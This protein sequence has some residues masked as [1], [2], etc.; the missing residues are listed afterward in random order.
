MTRSE[1]RAAI[2]ARMRLR[3]ILS[4]AVL[5]L[6]ACGSADGRPAGDSTAA[7]DTP[8]TEGSAQA[9]AGAAAATGVRLVRVASFTQP[10]Y[11]TAPP[12]DR[13]RQ[14]V[15]E[16][17][18][19]IMIVRN[20][21]K[22]SRPFLD[23]RS[24]VM[25]GGE[26][27]LLGLAF[28]PDYQTS[29]RFYVYFTDRQAKQRLVG[30]R[31]ADADRANPATAE[32]VFVHDDPEANH[33]GGMITFGPDGHLYVGTG[34]GGGGGDQHG[35][36]GNAQ[37]LSSPLGKLLRIDP[38]A[39]GGFTVPSDNPFRTRAGARPEIYAYGLRNPWRFSFDRRSGDLTI[40][41]VGQDTV[42]E[43]DFTR[44]GR[45]R[46]ANFG[47]RPLEGTRVQ[48]PGESAA[49]S[50]RPV[51]QET[52]GDGWCSITGGYV[53]RDPRVPALAG[54]YLFSD[55]CKNRIYQ[56]RLRSGRATSVRALSLR[57]VSSIVSF[58]EDTLGRVYAV[59]LEGPVYRFAAA[60]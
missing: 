1:R 51:I 13:T 6:V 58:G 3:V 16:Q 32:V 21:R 31:R 43:I 53:V 56:A 33:N 10:L 35:A 52:H 11:L 18:G 44:K 47:W 41:D 4:T 45:A 23:I 22:L 34:D 59:S 36:R 9:N 2:L 42:E 27:G 49:G 19:R 15:V 12:S 60:R 40:G 39:G 48:T 17:G 5:G 26:Q 7:S 38:K 20:G 8:A 54:R 25:S 50:I 29:G 55:V 30:Y 57:S 24:Q 37:N 14:F 46:A 28:A